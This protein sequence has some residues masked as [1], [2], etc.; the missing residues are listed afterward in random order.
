MFNRLVIALVVTIIFYLAVVYIPLPV[1]RLIEVAYFLI[2]ALY[3]AFGDHEKFL[4]R[5]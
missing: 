1:P 4:H 2:A 5:P 3:V